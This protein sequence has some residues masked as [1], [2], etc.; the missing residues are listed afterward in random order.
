MKESNKREKEDV[1]NAIRQ[2]LKV[3]KIRTI[4]DW[5]KKGNQGKISKSYVSKKKD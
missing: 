4:K 2:Y 5:Y 1:L 3:N